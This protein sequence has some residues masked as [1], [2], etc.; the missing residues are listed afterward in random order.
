MAVPTSAS[1][2]FHV[3][4]PF[5][6]WNEL[7]D[8]EIWNYLKTNAYFKEIG[9]EM[10]SLSANMKKDENLWELTL[11][12]PMVLSVHKTRPKD[13]DFLYVIDL[14][15][16]TQLNFIKN[17]ITDFSDD[18]EKVYTRAYQD[19]E[20]IEIK[21]ADSPTVYYLFSY[22]NLLSISTTHTLIEQAIDQLDKPILIRDLAFVDITK[23]L[24][25]NE[26]NMY[27]NY[28]TLSDYLKIWLEDSGEEE[29][30]IFSVLNY[31]GM[32]LEANDEVFSV[33]GYSN[34]AKGKL[35]L[36]TA[37]INAGQGEIGVGTIVPDNASYF[38]SLGFDDPL[39]FYE[40]M[41]E[42]L[43]TTEEGNSYLD[44]KEK[45]ESYLN[46]S[47]Q[48]DFLSWIEDEIALIQ[49]NSNSDRNKVEL[50]VA[51]KHNGVK[52]TKER[53][54]YIEGQIRKKTPV[55]FKGISHQGYDIQFLSIK[56]FFKLLFGK[57]F[58][59]ID[60]PYYTVIND[61]V[62]FSNSARTLGKIISSVEN[63]RT[64]D[65][66]K[67]YAVFMENF[68][69]ASNLFIYLSTEELLSDAE[70]LLVKSSWQDLKLHQAYFKSFPMIGMQFKADGDLLEH[71]LQMNYLNHKQISNWNSLVAESSEAE[72]QVQDT[73][74]IKDEEL[75]S[76]E[77]ILPE[78]LSSN[79][80]IEYYQNEQIKFEVSLKDGLKH[81]R[82][83]QFDSLGNMIVKGRYREDEKSGTWRFYDKNGDLIRKERY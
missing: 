63:K 76:A 82:Y 11:D 9:Q 70:R 77:S 67:E 55:K 56:G 80:F 17:Y 31:S 30:D 3:Q 73:T 12:R 75:I 20:I 21:F 64:L 34:L 57:A 51:I 15:R 74:K 42:V 13:Y 33:K 2:I 16:A 39:E 41:E 18:I 61:Y 54:A 23:A 65:Q 25:S 24:G 47:I 8:N 60:K 37:L 49:L 26:I 43:K 83:F 71:Q 10:D 58:E 5:Q 1:F 48:D 68:D 29:N 4:N 81:G 7:A 36:L 62:V 40:Q 6:Q 32:S 50:A 28:S 44:S 72:E 35:N 38:M 46:I 27:I 59:G 22:E 69:Y 45:L 52:D 19:Q 78:D 53:L 14:Q 66:T 79:T